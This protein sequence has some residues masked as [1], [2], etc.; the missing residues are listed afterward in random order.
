MPF[1]EDAIN[2]LAHGAEFVGKI[3]EFHIT[4]I[5]DRFDSLTYLYG[6]HMHVYV[7]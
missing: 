7:K 6:F 3:R 2:I 5:E 1:F 4:V